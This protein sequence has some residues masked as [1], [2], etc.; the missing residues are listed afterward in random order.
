MVITA[1]SVRFHDDIETGLGDPEDDD[2]PPPAKHDPS[3]SSDPSEFLWP[4]EHSGAAVPTEPAIVEPFFLLRA[5][6]VEQNNLEGAGLDDEHPDNQ[7]AVA[8]VKVT[9]S[10][11][12]ITAALGGVLDEALVLVNVPQRIFS[13]GSLDSYRSI[14]ED[15][16]RPDTA[17]P[18]SAVIGKDP[19][20]SGTAA[21][22]AEDVRASFAGVEVFLRVF[23]PFVDQFVQNRRYVSGVVQAIAQPPDES[24]ADLGSYRAM[25]CRSQTTEFQ[26]IQSSAD[27]GIMTV[28]SRHLKLGLILVPCSACWPCATSCQ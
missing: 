3:T 23:E 17:T 14:Q 1:S 24:E 16:D 15:A 9:P 19:Q 2:S 25:R 11:Q 28:D 20:Y 5:E 4:R 8:T 26:R 13:D 6:I 18:L 21:M 12:E 7:A 27:V 10:V 22:V